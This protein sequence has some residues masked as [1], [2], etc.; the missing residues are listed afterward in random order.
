M[1][2]SNWLKV[3]VKN[4]I[5][6]T[7]VVCGLVALFTVLAF[8][9]TK[10]S[11]TTKWQYGRFEDNLTGKEQE[12]Y[13]TLLSSNKLYLKFPY[14]GG[15][16]AKLIIYENES[17]PHAKIT[18]LNDANFGGEYSPRLQFDDGDIHNIYEEFIGYEDDLRRKLTFRNKRYCS[19]DFNYGRTQT[20]DEIQ[21]TAPPF[22]FFDNLKKSKQMKIDTA[23]YENGPQ[24]LIFDTAGLDVSI[25]SDAPSIKDAKCNK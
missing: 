23:V 14:D 25:I 15:V 8:S 18:F 5:A 24:V 21:G 6:K 16:R 17:G 9:L 13:A 11:E 2:P 19:K 4:K 12:R 10:P 20:K 7:L 22:D 3:P 1:R